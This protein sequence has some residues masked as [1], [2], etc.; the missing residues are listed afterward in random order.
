MCDIDDDVPVHSIQ[1][2]YTTFKDKT[3]QQLNNFLLALKAKVNAAKNMEKEMGKMR[4]SNKC[5]IDRLTV[6]ND[7]NYYNPTD[8]K[9]H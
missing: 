7:W 1:A 5:K 9:H 2:M 8:Y 6:N 4:E 3:E